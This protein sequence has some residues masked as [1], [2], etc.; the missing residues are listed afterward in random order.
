MKRTLAETVD[1]LGRVRENIA[2]LT[3]LEE[4]LRQ[5]LVEAGVADADGKLFRVTVTHYETAVTDWKAIAEKMQPSH[6]LV[7]AHTSV[8]EKSTVKTFSQ[9]SRKVRDSV[10]SLFR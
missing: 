1:A 9:K 5:E 7:S 8:V 3:R 2:E 6:Q 10:K 4:S